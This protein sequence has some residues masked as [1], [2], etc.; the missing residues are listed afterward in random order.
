MAGVITGG[1]PTS[2]GISILPSNGV[3]PPNGGGPGDDPGAGGPTG[4]GGTGGN[5]GQGSGSSSSSGGINSKVQTSPTATVS[6]SDTLPSP[7]STSISVLP[8]PTIVVF[9]D[10]A[11]FGPDTSGRVFYADNQAKLFSWT[12]DSA[13]TPVDIFWYGRDVTG[14]AFD[15]SQAT[16]IASAKFGGSRPSEF[17]TLNSSSTT[18]NLTASDVTDWYMK[19]MVIK[20]DWETQAEETGFSQSGVFTV[21]K[22]GSINAEA[23]GLEATQFEQDRQGGEDITSNG[24][25][26]SPTI[27]T[28][29]SGNG[30]GIGNGIDNGIDKGSGG[31]GKGAI[32]GIS[33]ACSVVGIALIGALVWFLLRRR[34]LRRRFDDGYKATRQTTGSFIA[35]G[36]FTATKEAQPS[37]A[38]SPAV[39]PFSDDGDARAIGASS[40][41][42]AATRA[43]TTR[44]ASAHDDSG[45]DRPDTAASGNRS[46]NIAHLVEEGMTEADILRLEEEER[47]LDAEIERAARRTST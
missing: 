35:T 37:A 39:S 32:A 34:R 3:L 6:Q 20:I 18:L 8:S 46:R 11:N 45:A 25:P 30:N 19:E 1:V 29:G 33:V 15:M 28:G 2:T 7:S 38:D 44:P 40:G 5:I 24:K 27:P 42:A 31:L 41:T 16:I 47:H 10:K 43:V 21:A 9:N 4:G 22:R 36:S 13:T 23:F 12:H 26:S 14:Q 17:V